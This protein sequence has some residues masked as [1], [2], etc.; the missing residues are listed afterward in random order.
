VGGAGGSEGL[1]L[2]S[3]KLFSVGPEKS[4]HSGLVFFARTLFDSRP[5][6]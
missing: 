5:R 4:I 1:M 3:P 6:G 2:L